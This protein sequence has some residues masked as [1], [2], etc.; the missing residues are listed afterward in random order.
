[1]STVY[2]IQLE[3]LV[4][5][6]IMV[7]G[8]EPV[9]SFSSP[10]LA[11][12]M[13]QYGCEDPLVDVEDALNAI[14]GSY[15]KYGINFNRQGFRQAWFVLPPFRTDCVC[16]Q[17]Q[18]WFNILRTLPR[19]KMPEPDQFAE[20]CGVNDQGFCPRDFEYTPPLPDIY[21]PEGSMPSGVGVL[22]LIQ[23]WALRP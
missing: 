2:S 7:P 4:K 23:P 22:P 20:E 10:R 18:D 12:W 9:S 21:R 19:H 1:M 13:S 6:K 17:Q 5:S 14:P 15:V 3:I 8:C 16:E 11:Y